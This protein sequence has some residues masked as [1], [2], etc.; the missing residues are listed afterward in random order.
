MAGVVVCNPIHIFA[1]GPAGRALLLKRCVKTKIFHQIS[2]G[3]LVL[4]GQSGGSIPPKGVILKKGSK[5]L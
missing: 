1:M 4:F 3:I 5:I 2:H